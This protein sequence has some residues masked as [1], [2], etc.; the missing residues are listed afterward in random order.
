MLLNNVRIS[1]CKTYEQKKEVWELFFRMF[2]N[3]NHGIENVAEYIEKVC[4]YAQIMAVCDN[5]EAIGFIAFYA[6]DFKTQTAYVT[7]FL[8][9]QKYRNR[10]FGKKLLSKCEAECKKR[11]FLR[12]RLEVR[13]DNENAISFYEHCGFIRDAKTD[14]SIYMEKRL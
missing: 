12:L 13:R 5:N 14:K 1:E 11:G 6:N 2:P 8:I 4:K 7:Q 9:D 3:G 10:G